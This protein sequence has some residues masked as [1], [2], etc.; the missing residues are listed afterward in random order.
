MFVNLPKSLDA[1]YVLLPERNARNEKKQKK[2]RQDIFF[3]RAFLLYIEGQNAF[4]QSI[5]AAGL[6]FPASIISEFNGTIVTL[7]GYFPS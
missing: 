5:L 1:Y 6:T 7:Y 2:A 4:Y 3:L